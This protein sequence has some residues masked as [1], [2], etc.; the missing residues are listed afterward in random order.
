MRK[1]TGDNRVF[2]ELH[3]LGSIGNKG[4]RREEQNTFRKKKKNL[5]WG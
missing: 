3:K 1:I 2:P 4:L 5:Q